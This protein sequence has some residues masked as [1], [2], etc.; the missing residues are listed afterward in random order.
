MLPVLKKDG[1]AGSGSS[2]KL[3]AERPGSSSGGAANLSD[4]AAAAADR[5][6]TAPRQHARPQQ[7]VHVV[8]VLATGTPASSASPDRPFQQRQQQPRQQ[9]EKQQ[10]DGSSPI[11]EGDEGFEPQVAEVSDAGV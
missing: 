8:P 3:Q 9:Q 7:E 6:Q 11:V 10:Q 2:S 4:S 5:L 1:S